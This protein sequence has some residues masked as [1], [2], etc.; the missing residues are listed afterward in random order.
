M[1]NL[2]K[3]AILGSTG[4]TSLELIKILKDHPNVS[5]NFLN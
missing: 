5:I 2:I 4:Y 1:N 3:V